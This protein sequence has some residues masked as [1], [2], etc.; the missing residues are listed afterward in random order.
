MSTPALENFE[1]SDLRALLEARLLPL[2]PASPATA[3]YSDYDLTP[4]LRPAGFGPLT[5]AAVLAPII[6]RPAGWTM[7][8][9]LRA[10]DLPNHPGQVSFPGGRLQA[11]DAN[12]VAAALRE[13]EEEI[14]LDAAWISPIGA[15]DPYLTVTGFHVQPIIALIEPGFT[16]RLDPREVAAVFEVPL[17]VVLDG[18]RYR[19]EEQMWRGHNRRYYVLDTPD[20]RIW[21]ATAGMLKALCDRLANRGAHAAAV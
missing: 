14:G 9:T 6:L 5:A 2:V 7:L 12:E 8:F 1:A 19:A 11:E 16:L 13:T 21:G 20:H 4:E 17:A 3:A 18:A 15:G 10:A